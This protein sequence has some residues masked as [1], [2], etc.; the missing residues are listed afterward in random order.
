MVCA[1]WICLQEPVPWAYFDYPG[2]I[3]K[4]LGALDTTM[5][6]TVRQM[7]TY[8]Y[9]LEAA[10]YAPSGGISDNLTVDTADV[11]KRN[12]NELPERMRLYTSQRLELCRYMQ[13]NPGPQFPSSGGFGTIW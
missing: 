2:L 4:K 11:F 12:K 5:I 8:L 1:A 9:A 3:D 7:L 10:L 13:L 6:N